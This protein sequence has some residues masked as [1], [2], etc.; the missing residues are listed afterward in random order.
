[1]R[2]HRRP[3]KGTY[4]FFYDATTGIHVAEAF[5]TKRF[6]C[7]AS[8]IDVRGHQPDEW[9]DRLSEGYEDRMKGVIS[10]VHGTRTGG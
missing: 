10:N 6:R 3:P 5:Q 4:V 9:D 2:K 7:V 8:W 1:M